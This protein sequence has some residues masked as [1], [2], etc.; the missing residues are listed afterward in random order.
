M[1]IL[2]AYLRMCVVN[3]APDVPTSTGVRQ[4]PRTT[5]YAAPDPS[6]EENSEYTVEDAKLAEPSSDTVA[7]D[8][9]AQIP[10]M[11]GAGGSPVQSGTQEDG[12]LG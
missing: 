8:L 6:S 4:Q 10:P 1:C 3:S 11:D 2:N 9:D 5:S 7:H 12:P